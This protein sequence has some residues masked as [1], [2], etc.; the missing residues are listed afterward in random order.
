MTRISSTARFVRITH[1]SQVDAIEK[2]LLLKRNGGASERGETVT[3]T[4][5]NTGATSADFK[6]KKS[7]KRITQTNAQRAPLSLQGRTSMQL[8]GGANESEEEFNDAE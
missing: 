1:K 6:K 7:N 4:A 8:P 2:E 3:A 5:N